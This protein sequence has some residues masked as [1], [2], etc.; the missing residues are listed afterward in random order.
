MDTPVATVWKA[1][2]DF[3]NVYQFH[4]NLEHSESIN[5]VSSGKGAKRLCAFSDGNTIR[6]E[7]LE[8]VPEQRQIVRVFDLG[9]FPMK[10]MVNSLDLAPIDEN[11]TEV[12]LSMSFV[13]KYGPVGWLMATVIMK[14]QLHDQAEDILE[15]LDTHLQ[16]GEVVGSNSNPETVDA[17]TAMAP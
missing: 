12:S 11:S 8:S 2:D 16:T 13:P 6:E 1:I 3:G 9:S 4:P 15:G 5:E 10:E 7:V 17:P 14:S